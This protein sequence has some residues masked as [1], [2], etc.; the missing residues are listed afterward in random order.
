MEACPL[1]LRAPALPRLALV[2]A[3]ER[4]LGRRRIPLA[5]CPL[6]LWRA[7]PRQA[8]ELV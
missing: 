6:A 2:P 3:L 5:G 8:W 4:V 7:L 1:A